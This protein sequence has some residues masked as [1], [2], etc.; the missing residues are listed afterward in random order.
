MSIG[1]NS[2]SVSSRHVVIGT[3]TP[4]LG[5]ILVGDGATAAARA[6]AIADTPR[7]ERS[8][9]AERELV[10]EAAVAERALLTLLVAE[11]ARA[12]WSAASAGVGAC[13]REPGP[14]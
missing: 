6:A 9:S 3:D 7:G 5:S 1:Q 2:S 14:A 8:R 13:P 11:R 4:L 10:A 12:A